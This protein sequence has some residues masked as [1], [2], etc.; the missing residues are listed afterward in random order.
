MLTT[1]H[2]IPS[3]R[4]PKLSCSRYFMPPRRQ[5]RPWGFSLLSLPPWLFLSAGAAL[6]LPPPVASGIAFARLSSGNTCHF[7]VFSRSITQRTSHPSKL[8]GTFHKY[9]LSG[10]G[11]AS[12]SVLAST[13]STAPSPPED[14]AEALKERPWRTGLEPAEDVDLIEV[15]AACIEVRGIPI[16]HIMKNL[17]VDFWLPRHTNFGAPSK[18]I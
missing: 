16:S 6:A 7:S 5:A 17:C 14:I 9:Y 8:P 15:S 2:P 18:L 4:R 12:S 13:L 1:S 10:I 3:P 11:S